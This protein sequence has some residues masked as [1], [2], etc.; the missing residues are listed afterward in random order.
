MSTPT[1]PQAPSQPAPFKPTIRVTVV[2]IFIFATL[3]T[4]ALAVGL[5]YHFS[6]KMETASAVGRFGQLAEST[7]AL[8]SSIDDRAMDTTRILASYPDLVV[9]QWIKGDV[10]NLFAAIMRDNHAFYSI[11]IGFGNGDFYEVINLDSSMLARQNLKATPDDRWVV[12][13]IRGNGEA[14]QR[15]FAYYSTDFRLRAQRSEPS[16]FNATVRPWF[17]QAKEGQV[18]KTAP[19]LFHNLQ[20]PGQTYSTRIRGGAVVAIDIA[21]STIS[22]N[23]STRQ[24]SQFGEIFLFRGNGDLTASN[25]PDRQYPALT[26]AELLPLSKSEQSLLADIGTLRISNET[27]W[28]PVDFSVSGEPQGYSVDFIKLLATMLGVEVKF[29]NGYSWPELVDLYRRG[30]IDILQ[31]LLKDSQSDLPGI[32]SQPILALPY[33]LITNPGRDNIEHFRQLAGSTL[34]VPEGWTIINVLRR[35]YP[36]ITITT[37][38]DTRGV[39]EAVRSGRADAGLDVGRILHYTGKTYFFNDVQY[40]DQVDFSPVT[41]PT[42]LHLLTTERYAALSPLIDRAIEAVSTQQKQALRE[43]WFRDHS[44]RSGS[45]TVPYAELVTIAGQPQQH[46][47]LA[48]RQINGRQSY[49]FVVPIGIDGSG[50]DYFGIVIPVAQVLQP[51][52]EKVQLSILL[53]VAFLLLLIPAPWIFSSPIVGPIKKLAVENDKIRER[54]YDELDIPDSYIK[55]IHE[56]GESMNTMVAAIRQH[57]AQQIALMDSFIQLIATAIDDKSHYTAGHCERVPEL[58]FMLAEKAEATRSGPFRDFA[59]KS[60]EEWREFRV[61]AWLHDC[62]KITTPEHIVDKGSKLETIYNRIHEVRMRFEVLW[63]DAAIEYWQQV[64]EKPDRQQEYQQ[65][66][67]ARHE[68]LQDDF[69]FVATM[70]VGGEFL[71]DDKKQRLMGLASQTWTRHFSDRLGLSPLEETRL[72]GEEPPLP[73]QEQLLSD[74][75]GHIIPRE[76]D[77]DFD[78]QL[79]IKMEIPVDLYNQGELYNLCIER[80]TLT[81][82]DRFKINEHIISTI[83]MLDALPFPPELARVPRYASTHHE[84]MDGHGYPRQLTGDQLSI[85]ERIMVLADIF[86]ALTAS[87]R[88]Y[89]KAKPVSVAIDILAKMVE[90]QHVDPDVFELFLVSGVYRDYAQRFLPPEQLDEVDI[91]AY[92][93][94]AS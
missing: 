28:A 35:E 38:P 88:P 70:N 65:Q 82:E 33:A 50:D 25:Q 12:I 91:S 10:R 7:G 89:K 26:D 5:Q 77:T 62:G 81:A 16:D 85:P 93:R 71:S 74:K 83:R 92:L 37:V 20:A 61:G 72:I 47:E 87:D 94:S 34:A 32:Y 21:L 69:R 19:Y 22:E 57:E 64:A 45:T 39:F 11:Y 1:S 23:L 44:L 66:L 60:E 17:I 42:E 51:A 27:N 49:V 6:S 2:S 29:V 41:P 68:Q 9:D 54:R 43:K 84:S 59:F 79:G 3:L 8:L 13:T 31:P 63:R 76:H 14:R 48:K 56:L 52:L 18:N 40:H 86:E 80:G 58:A 15:H 4:A 55:E 24:T 46:R 53:T 90:N 78:P 73:C 30:S 75:A 67:R 36:D